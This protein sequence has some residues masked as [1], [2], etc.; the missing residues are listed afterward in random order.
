MTHIE[1]HVTGASAI[2]KCYGRLTGGM[3]GV[4]VQVFFNDA[5]DGL[6]KTGYARAGSVEKIV[7]LDGTGKGTVP[8]ECMVAGGD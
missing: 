8:W 5:W 2:A 4:P 1:I 3:V 7:V 6:T